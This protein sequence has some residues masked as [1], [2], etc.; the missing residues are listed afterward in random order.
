MLGIINNIFF[1]K[2]IAIIGSFLILTLRILFCRPNS[3]V[4]FTCVRQVYFLGFKTLILIMF[5][6]CFIGL[7][8]AFQGYNVL[9]RFAAEG[10]LGILVGLS[11]F[12]ELA[13]VLSG[14]LFVGS[15]GTSLT[16][17]IALMKTTDQIAN[18][19]ILSVDPVERVLSP[20]FWASI[21]VFP[22][23]V[24]T[25]IFSALTFANF[26][27]S[28]M[29]Q[30][31]SVFWF[32]LAENID[33]FEDSLY[34]LIKS[35]SFGFIISLIAIFNGYY[36]SPTPEGLVLATNNTVVLSSIS[37]LLVDLILTFFMFG[38]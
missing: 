37:I 38:G 31:S 9:E 32:S 6:A 7:V 29:G 13:P 16:S 24:F 3:K 14:L 5:S 11:L 4:F 33:Y 27:Y 23:L 28:Y 36:S 22:F 18:L 1:L 26:L 35:I 30:S 10:A 12:R 34:C 17:E 20:R 8:L 19:D 25:F 21:I 15:V 2:R